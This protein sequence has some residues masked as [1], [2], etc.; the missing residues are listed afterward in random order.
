[1]KNNTN[2]IFCNKPT[3]TYHDCRVCNSCKTVS[4]FSLS[5]EELFDEVRNCID[6]IQQYIVGISETLHD[7][8]GRYINHGLGSPPSQRTMFSSSCQPLVDSE[9]TP[10]C[11]T[12]SFLISFISVFS[13]LF[14]LGG[15]DRPPMYYRLKGREIVPARFGSPGHADNS[16]RL[17]ARYGSDTGPQRSAPG[18]A[19]PPSTISV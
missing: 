18:C 19:S 14:D 11:R 13:F 10:M 7:I 12:I 16:G 5:S 3:S 2:C 9:I 17:P 15:Q 8:E 4:N 1:M 6:S